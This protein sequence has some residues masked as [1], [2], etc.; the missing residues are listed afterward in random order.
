MASN[1]VSTP[2]SSLADNSG[3]PNPHEQLIGA[4]AGFWVAKSIQVAASLKLA[5]H[6][7]GDAARAVGDLAASTGTHA[8]S[9]YR[10]MRALASAGIFAEEGHGRFRH[11]P[12]SRLLR[13][14]EPGSMRA[15]F[16][17]VLGGGHY[18]AWGALEHSVKTGGIAFD[19]VHGEDVWAWFAKHSHEQRTF[20]GAM[21]D[22]S[23]VFNPAIAKALDLS[24]AKTLID[25][26]GGHGVLLA[27]LLAAN[28]HL[29][30]VLFDQPHVVDGGRARLAAEHLAGRGTAVAGDFFESVP[31]GADACLMK[32]ILHDW[33]DERSTRILR[34][35]HK[36]LPAGGRLLVVET[37][38]PPGN[39]PGLG[40]LGDINMLVM[41]GGRERTEAEFAKLFAAAGFDLVKTHP[42]ESPFGIVEGVKR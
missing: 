32:F 15:F 41:T 39:T 35:V 25:V 28:P 4:L 38:L 19:H 34:N 8:D 14:G 12:A 30:G 33:D 21:S 2:Q 5:D 13:T 11:T 6:I 36:A 1:A 10:L 16:E 23:A 37:V 27:S 7:E 31:V 20:D 24:N 3:Q 29:R 40:K 9:L 22:M 42:T 17:S 18:A 26:G